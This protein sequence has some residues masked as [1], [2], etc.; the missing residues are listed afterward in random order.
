MC[1]YNGFPYR[2]IGAIGVGDREKPDENNGVGFPVSVDFGNL[3]TD[4]KMSV[5]FGGNLRNKR[6]KKQLSVFGSQ[7]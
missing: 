1:P 6:P 7:P 4:P 2:Y 5:S 3:K